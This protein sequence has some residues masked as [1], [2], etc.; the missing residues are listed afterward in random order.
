MEMMLQGAESKVAR[1]D[2]ALHASNQ[3]VCSWT[4]LVLSSVLQDLQ[5]RF[6]LRA[7]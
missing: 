6:Y 1:L 7:A 4:F 2:D 3:E 5:G